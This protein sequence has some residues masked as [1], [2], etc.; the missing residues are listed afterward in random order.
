MTDQAEAVERLPAGRFTWERDLRASTLSIRTKGVAMIMASYANA[1]GAS[2]RPGHTQLAADTSV[3]VATLKRAL[4]ELHAAGFIDTVARG[5]SYGRGGGGFASEYRLTLPRAS[6]FPAIKVP[7]VAPSS[8]NNGSPVSHSSV[9]NN[10]SIDE[11]NGSPVQ[12]KGS[13]QQEQQLT[14]EP[15]PDHLTPDHLT[16]RH[17]HQSAEGHQGATL[18]DTMT[19]IEESA[20]AKQDQEEREQAARKHLND[21]PGEH[22]HAMA[23]ARAAL[24]DDAPTAAR[25]IYAAKLTGWKWEATG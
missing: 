19:K 5:R 2:I 6:L 15:P 22:S 8:D 12:N 20:D 13:N 25:I 18:A 14:S 23:R 3:S 11:N 4:A 24:G 1:N 7:P 21:R 17:F 10:S 16:T 9:Q